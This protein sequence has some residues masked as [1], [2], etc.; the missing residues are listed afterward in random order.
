MGN[1]IGADRAHGVKRS[2]RHRN[3]GCER[4]AAGAVAGH[5][6]S[7]TGYQSALLPG[8]LQGRTLGQGNLTGDPNLNAKPMPSLLWIDRATINDRL[9]FEDYRRTI[10]RVIKG[11]ARC[12]YRLRDSPALRD[13]IVG[14]RVAETVP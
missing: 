14:F 2:T 6:K 11:Y 4:R 12:A 1:R 10:V 9:G 8:T 7:R 13:D 3:A 5:G